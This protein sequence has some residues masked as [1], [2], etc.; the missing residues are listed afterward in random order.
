MSASLVILEIIKRTPIWV[1]AILAALIGVGL[2]NLRERLY[3]RTR[4]VIVPIAL[5]A[6][7]LWG[8]TA[9]FGVRPEVITAWLAGLALAVAANRMLQ[10]PR[11]V[12]PDG[13]G[14]FRVPGSVWPLVLMLAIFSL[15]YVATV[16]LVLHHD[17]A[18]DAQFSLGMAL[19]YGTL[20]G[21]FTAR[22]LRILDSERGTMSLR[23]A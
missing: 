21:L 5:G 2:I 19:A 12:R 10:W 4:L 1:W 11:N 13:K 3:S 23:T 9:A 16:T 17:W 8:A 14:N 18:A 20:S 6:Y 22:A 15:R 7:S